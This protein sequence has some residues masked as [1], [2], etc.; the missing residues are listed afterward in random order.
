MLASRNGQLVREL[1]ADAEGDRALAE[2]FGNRFFVHR[3]ATGAATLEKGIVTGELRSDLD[4]DDALDALY[5]PLWLRLLVGHRP[6][7]RAAA[8][9]VLDLVRPGLEAERRPGAGHRTATT[10]RPEAR[11]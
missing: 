8:D 3:R 9:R 6:L 4:V 11:R 5:G 10:R 2:D 7:S 1:V